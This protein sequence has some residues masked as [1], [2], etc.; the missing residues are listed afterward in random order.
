MANADVLDAY[1]TFHALSKSSD[2]AERLASEDLLWAYDTVGDA[3]VRGGP[4]AVALLVD[5]ADTAP[6]DALGYLGAGPFEELL[7]L[8]AESVGD[9]LDAAL[10]TNAKLRQAMRSV[11]WGDDVPKSV[12]DRLRRYESA[13]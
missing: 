10:R 12:V 13:P 4:D 1:W 6:D 7:A 3:M 9:D 8:H 2:R 5:L 11:Y